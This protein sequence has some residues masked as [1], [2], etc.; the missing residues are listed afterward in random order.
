[1]G[2]K[3]TRLGRDKA[4]AD[5]IYL[6]TQLSCVFLLLQF[7]IRPSAVYLLGT[8]INSHNK[9]ETFKE[10][11]DETIVEGRIKMKQLER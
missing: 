4:P 5:R 9:N 3:Q 8:D 11:K 2:E 6:G 10:K 1:M 7:F